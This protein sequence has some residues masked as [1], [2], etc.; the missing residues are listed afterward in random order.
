MITFLI[1]LTFLLIINYEFKKKMFYNRLKAMKRLNPEPGDILLFFSDV[2]G[3]IHNYLLWSCLLTLH[4]SIPSVHYGFV[5]NNGYYVES[6]RPPTI[7]WDNISK[8]HKGGPRIGK[9][10]HMSKD[11]DYGY[12]AVIRTNIS[13]V[14]DVLIDKGY[15]EAGGCL[16]IVN[17][18]I[19]KINKNHTYCLSPESFIKKYGID[20]GLWTHSI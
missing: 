14:P 10:K 20:I 16:G 9:I 17:N 12:I 1:L 13:E 4:T 3:K 5:L 15:W 18:T 11:W 2:S 6:R 8:K 7:R 19:K